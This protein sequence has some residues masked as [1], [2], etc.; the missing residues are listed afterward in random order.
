MIYCRVMNR[1]IP[2]TALVLLSFFKAHS[3]SKDSLQTALIH[4]NSSQYEKALPE[5]MALSVRFEKA[6]NWENF[7]LCQIK[8]A[9][10]IRAYGGL[11]LSIQL[12]EQNEKKILANLKPNHPNLSANFIAKA[13]AWYL[14]RKNDLFKQA[15]LKSISI[16]KEFYGG[17]TN[18]LA[19][20]YWQMCRFY[21]NRRPRDS[22]EYWGQKALKLAK[23]NK[24]NF[25]YLL[26][27]IYNS[28]GYFIHT[29][30]P[31]PANFK[32]S[33]CY[34]DSAL[35]L[36]LAQPI[37]D[38]ISKGRIC[39]NI[40]N[41][42]NDAIGHGKPQE[43]FKTAIKYYDQSIKIFKVF[44]SPTELASI[45]WV[46]AVAYERI[47]GLLHPKHFQDSS[48]HHF[49][50]GIKYLMPDFHPKNDKEVPTTYLTIN[51]N[52][53]LTFINRKGRHLLMW[54]KNPKDLVNTWHHFFYYA[55]FYRWVL[56]RTSSENESVDWNALYDGNTYNLLAETSFQLFKQTNDIKYIY[57]SYSSTSLAKYAS[58]NKVDFES[59]SVSNANQ[60]VLQKEYEI[61]QRNLKR[62]IRNLDWNLFISLIEIKNNKASKPVVNFDPR[63]KLLT[64]SFSITDIQ[65]KALDKNTALLDFYTFGYK[66]QILA[67]TKNE[68]IPVEGKLPVGF[69]KDIRAFIANKGGLTPKAYALAASK[70]YKHVLDSTLRK[71]PK[72]INRL[73]IS[74]DN[75]LQQLPWDG[76]VK[77]T[78]VTDSYKNLDYLLNHYTI[79]VV[80]SPALLL[81]PSKIYESP[82]FGIAPGF[83]DSKKF[84]T[85][86]FSTNLVKEKALTWNG[87]MIK[88]NQWLT[89]KKG[90]KIF[91]LA[92]HI[93]IDS[94]YPYRSSLFLSDQDSV[95][96][97]Q[98]TGKQMNIQ[99]AVLN[100]CQTGIGQFKTGEGTIS[101]ARAFFRN[102]AQSVLMSLWNV[103]DMATANV[104]KYFYENI[105]ENLPLDKSL[106]NAKLEYLKNARTDEEANPF[107]WAGLSITGK[108][109]P[110]DYQSHDYRWSLSIF[111]ILCVGAGGVWLKKKVFA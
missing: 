35:K 36:V 39:H 69:E 26:P 29:E 107:Y 77:D 5:F 111:A 79:S 40:G 28:L 103:D 53:L 68:V 25:K 10:M 27:N 109:D 2:I 47:D 83:E 3:G 96:I 56:S 37:Q 54:S 31:R 87:E 88:T 101:F 97:G 102:G 106:R 64:G 70:I 13:E 21:L 55:K 105:Q 11:N 71:L 46:K 6:K 73:I 20:D 41:S 19:E 81:K 50:N 42:F 61:V 16:K 93:T 75:Y 23:T 89:A 95:T 48:I 18:L 9:D 17:S 59:K 51:D 8:L 94:K 72:E 80:L 90:I 74:P 49:Q 104:L 34:F 66:I 85:I 100:G 38:R 62:N 78:A 86:P 24:G 84:T 98:F 43:S 58:L 65:K 52:E 22:A 60:Y 91:H 12:L 30:Q 1:C 108:T 82:F 32:L 45:E 67:I 33:R 44:G 99:L 57:Q 92:T 76:L 110:I 14:L 7:T 4:F 63:K 15:I